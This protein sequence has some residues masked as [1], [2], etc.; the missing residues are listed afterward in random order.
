MIND[1]KVSLSER[2]PA[3]KKPKQSLADDDP[4]DPAEGSVSNKNRYLTQKEDNYYD[5]FDERDIP[6]EKA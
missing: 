3:S 1:E 5:L 4:D 6:D 2:N